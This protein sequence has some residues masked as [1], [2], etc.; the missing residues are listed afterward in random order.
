MSA[1]FIDVLEKHK[2]INGIAH[3]RPGAGKTVLGIYMAHL[4]NL[5]T[6]IVIDTRKIVEQ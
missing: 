6:L 1:D 5:K 3:A 4:L 2:Y